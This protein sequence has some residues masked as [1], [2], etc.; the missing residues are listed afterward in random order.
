MVY[1]EDSPIADIRDMR[2]EMFP[3]SCRETIV[4]FQQ[5]DKLS[6][7]E[8]DFVVSYV[9]LRVKEVGQLT[10]AIR[11]AS[12]D[13]GGRMA[14]V[15]L[16]KQVTI[17]NEPVK[18]WAIILAQREFVNNACFL[19]SRGN[20][21]VKIEPV[22]GPNLYWEDAT[23]LTDINSAQKNKL[24]LKKL[25][26]QRARTDGPPYEEDPCRQQLDRLPRR[27]PPPTE[28][29]E[30]WEQVITS[31]DPKIRERLKKAERIDRCLTDFV[32][33]FA[34]HLWPLSRGLGISIDDPLPSADP[35][36][37]LDDHLDTIR[38]G[39]A[40]AFLT[41]DIINEPIYLYISPGLAAEVADA[42]VDQYTYQIDGD[43]QRFIIQHF[44]ETAEDF[45]RCAFE[46]TLGLK[47]K[48]YHIC[49]NQTAAEELFSE[50]AGAQMENFHYGINFGERNPDYPAGHL[51]TVAIPVKLLN[52]VQSRE[53]DHS[54]V[55]IS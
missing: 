12:A 53:T 21:Q 39:E 5:L 18:L 13:L 31:Q 7:D 49:A 36:V 29:E 32:V 2:L 52:F 54:T 25:L 35:N 4:K 24:Q 41:L 28:S 19:Y 37:I 47:T 40:S 6:D 43:V 1:N 51:L 15:F 33:L 45:L 48:R 9:M 27:N 50:Y 42:F 8:I 26:A 38:K 17:T 10:H 14:K 30:E 11:V 34:K 16:S 23:P 55:R 46:K 22:L 20:L 3:D 44:Y